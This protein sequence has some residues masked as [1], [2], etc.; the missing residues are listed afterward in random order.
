M[1]LWSDEAQ[2]FVNSYDGQFL[3][4]CRDSRCCVVY[5]TQSLPT[6]YSKMGGSTAREDAQ[7]LV[8]KFTTRVYGAN[9]CPD[10]NEYAS[11]VIGKVLTRRK[12]GSRGKADNF[13][14][15]MNTG[16]SE[17]S[18]SS[19]NSG[20]SS[21]YQGGRGNHGSNSGSGNSSGQG[22]NWGANKGRGTSRNENEGYSE[23][24]EYAIEPGDFARRLKTGG[25]QNG[26]IVTAIWFQSARKFNASGTNW[27]LVRFKQ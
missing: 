14:I 11:R 18:G 13:N 20:S 10:T 9:L 21:S 25:P 16:E 12:N 1:F 7:T 24:M 23:S 26:N 4:L 22:S 8:G 17:N 27:M 19:F 15:G 5:L 2:E 6:Y 3:G